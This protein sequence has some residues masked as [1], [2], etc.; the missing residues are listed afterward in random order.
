MSATPKL[1]NHQNLNSSQ[2]NEWFAP[3]RYTDAVREA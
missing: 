3:S 2:S 1:A